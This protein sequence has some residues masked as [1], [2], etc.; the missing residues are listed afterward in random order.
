MYLVMSDETKYHG[1]GDK[2]NHVMA[3]SNENMMYQVLSDEQIFDI[4][5]DK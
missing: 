4:L 5:G 3:L 1:M 2:N